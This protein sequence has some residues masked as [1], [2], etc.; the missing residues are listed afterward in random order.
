MMA[1]KNEYYS[2]M[3]FILYLVIS[4]VISVILFMSSFYTIRGNPT[5]VI[6]QDEIRINY[7]LLIPTIIFGILT[8]ISFI[9]LISFKKWGRKIGIA[10]NLIVTLLIILSMVLMILNPVEHYGK[11]M[12]FSNLDELLIP[13]ILAIYYGFNF[14]YL[15]FSRKVK[16]AFI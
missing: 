5:N 1:K 6:W 2:F 11:K 4:C 16:E 10:V 8:I 9:G 7:Y 3:I 13:L 12:Y 14:I 15:T